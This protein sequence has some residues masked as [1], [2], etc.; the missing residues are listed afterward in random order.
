MGKQKKKNDRNEKA[1]F[2]AQ[3]RAN[4]ELPINKFLNE[5]DKD[6]A[7]K[8]PMAKVLQNYF[9]ID[10]E[11]VLIGMRVCNALLHEIRFHKERAKKYYQASLDGKDK[12]DMY[13]KKGNMMSREECYIAYISETQTIQIVIGQLRKE[14][15]DNLL[16]KV[17]NDIFTFDK[18]NEY[19][20]KVIKKV[21]ELGYDLFPDKITLIEPL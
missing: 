10:V 16:I 21:K 13:D 7:L 3:Q 19:L 12:T 4:M 20:E 11:P 2:K 8:Y 14:L 18:Y 6:G 9:I 17:D 1:R 5:T 15:M